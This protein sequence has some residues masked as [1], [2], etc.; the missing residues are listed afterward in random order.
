MVPGTSEESFTGVQWFQ[1][2]SE[3][4]HRSTVVPSY[5][6]H[7]IS[8]FPC[9]T[10]CIHPW[11]WIL[12]E[13]LFPP[14]VSTLPRGYCRRNNHTAYIEIKLGLLAFCPT[15]QLPASAQLDK[16]PLYPSTLSPLCLEHITYAPPQF[17]DDRVVR[18]PH[19]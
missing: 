19:S 14:V 8:T 18:A 16:P 7:R 10:W 9:S 2:P 17:I 4:F 15:L 3:V 12:E 11:I 13:P 1:G 5:V 6:V